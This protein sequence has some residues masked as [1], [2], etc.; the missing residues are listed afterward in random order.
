MKLF[1][2]RHAQAEEA[3]NVNDLSRGLTIKG[4]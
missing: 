1:L 4:I 3:K 2:M